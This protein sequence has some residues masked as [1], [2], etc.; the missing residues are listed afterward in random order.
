M[1]LLD[2]ACFGFGDSEFFASA[3]C[4]DDWD[5]GTQARRFNPTRG[6]AD[7]VIGF[8]WMIA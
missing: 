4:V 8:G 2:W 5:A 3:L 6:L 1:G 7:I